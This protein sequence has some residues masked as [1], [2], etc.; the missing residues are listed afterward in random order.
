MFRSISMSALVYFLTMTVVLL[1]CCGAGGVA[2]ERVL[3]MGTMMMASRTMMPTMSHMRIFMSFH[4]ICLRTRFAPLRKPWADWAR[5][6]VLSC[7][8]SRRAP[9]SET[10]LM[11]SRMIPTVLSISWWTSQYL[12]SA[13]WQR[14]PARLEDGEHG[15]GIWR[16]LGYAVTK[17]RART[18]GLESCSAVVAIL[19][20]LATLTWAS[21]A[22]AWTNV[23]IIGRVVRVGHDGARNV[24]RGLLAAC[25]RCREGVS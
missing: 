24:C 16:L 9:L 3:P 8:E 7:S 25:D 22:A 23:G 18:Y 6:S 4:H 15:A 1:A 2:S 14:S 10:L 19:A 20:R 11:L 17:G 5:L 13:S 12:R 21:G